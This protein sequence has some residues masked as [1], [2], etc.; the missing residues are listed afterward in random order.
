MRQDN[1][2]TRDSAPCAVSTDGRVDQSGVRVQQDNHLTRDSAP[3]QGAA[4]FVLQGLEVTL[5]GQVVY[6]NVEKPNEDAHTVLLVLVA[7]G[8]A[9]VM[10][11]KLLTTLGLNRDASR[12]NKLSIALT[13]ARNVLQ[14]T[15]LTISNATRYAKKHRIER[16]DRAPI[17]S[18]APFRFLCINVDEAFRKCVAA[19]L[20]ILNAEAT[21]AD[22][23]DDALSILRF[24]SFDLTFCDPAGADPTRLEM[25]ASIIGGEKLKL[26]VEPMHSR[27]T[28]I[29][30]ITK[31]VDAE[32]VS[33]MLTH[34]GCHWRSRL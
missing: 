26:I 6:H 28:R 5:A 1:H 27:P 2:L 12:D 24:Q 30:V 21:F 19:V 11:E 10:R 13:A 15:H 34:N 23:L 29:T 14:D 20:G 8:G 7:A 32:V 16:R 18:V 25:L 3:F 4:R 22:S 9:D 33:A 31:P 17:P